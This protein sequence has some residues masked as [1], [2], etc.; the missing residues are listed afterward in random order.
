ML[1]LA[2]EVGLNLCID[3]SGNVFKRKGGAKLSL[4]DLESNKEETY[5]TPYLYMFFDE[6]HTLEFVR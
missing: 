1:G 4:R 6:H 2:C 5:L 3:H